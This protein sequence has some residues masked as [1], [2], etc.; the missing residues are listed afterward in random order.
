MAFVTKK[1][2]VRVGNVFLSPLYGSD[3]GNLLVA[4]SSTTFL[5]GGWSY[6]LIL[7]IVMYQP[8]IHRKRIDFF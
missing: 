3:A 6:D 1:S 2:E 4:I 5:F 8:H 7:D